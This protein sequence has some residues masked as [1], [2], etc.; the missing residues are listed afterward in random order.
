MKVQD[1]PP[2]TLLNI[3]YISITVIAIAAMVVSRNE[4][5]F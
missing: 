3:W 2:V 1:I 4:V 5:A